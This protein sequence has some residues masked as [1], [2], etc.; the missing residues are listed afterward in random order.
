MHTQ[1]HT[2]NTQIQKPIT[3]PMKSVTEECKARKSG[4]SV[5]VSVN[6]DELH[7]STQSGTHFTHTITTPISHFSTSETC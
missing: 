4:D 5:K 3:K 7:E 1:K 6:M 2:H